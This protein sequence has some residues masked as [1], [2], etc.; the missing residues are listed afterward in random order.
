MIDFSIPRFVLFKEIQ[1]DGFTPFATNYESSDLKIGRDRNGTITIQSGA[2]EKSRVLLMYTLQSVVEI[3]VV[4]RVPTLPLTNLSDSLQLLNATRSIASLLW[5]A[6]EYHSI[7]SSVAVNHSRLHTL[8]V[9]NLSSTL[10]QYLFLVSYPLIMPLRGLP[11]PSIPA[12]PSCSPTRPGSHP[13]LQIT[14]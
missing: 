11:P 10:M 2:Q 6:V 5:S 14:R 3:L 13:S 12:F 4:D 8:Y 1:L 7:A 9:F